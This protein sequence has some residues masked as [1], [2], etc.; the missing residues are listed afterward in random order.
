MVVATEIKHRI[1][2][3][4]R[5]FII[6]PFLRQYNIPFQRKKTIVIL[7]FSIGR[8]FELGPAP[9]DGMAQQRVLGDKKQYTL[10]TWHYSSNSLIMYVATKTKLRRA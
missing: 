3:F 1:S 5:Q 10:K 8:T 6:L 9:I 2:V 4:S 7:C